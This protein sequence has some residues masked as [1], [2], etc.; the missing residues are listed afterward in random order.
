MLLEK[1]ATVCIK[2][3]AQ[4]KSIVLGFYVGLEARDRLGYAARR[5][6]RLEVSNYLTLGKRKE[7]R[8]ASCTW[9]DR[10]W[11]KVEGVVAR[12]YHKGGRVQ[13]KCGATTAAVSTLHSRLEAASN[14]TAVLLEATVVTT[15][16]SAKGKRRDVGSG[17][18]V[19]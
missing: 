4:L 18:S 11:W 8:F 10:V 6:S 16:I 19:G 17:Y 2:N 7:E 14:A 13:E 15:C 5:I 3:A 12:R 1:E 9:S